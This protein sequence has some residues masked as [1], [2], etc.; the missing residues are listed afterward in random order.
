[1]STICE[2]MKLIQSYSSNE[3]MLASLECMKLL[4]SV[5]RKQIDL[6]NQSYTVDPSR[7]QDLDLMKQDL[8]YILEHKP[9]T[10]HQALQLFWLYALC[11]GCINY[12]RLDIV[13]GPFLKHDIDSGLIDEHEAYR[14]IKSLWKMIEN[15]RTTVNGRIIVG[16]K[17]RE[18]VEACDLFTRI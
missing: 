1:M 6:V 4:K 11:A 17:G 10:F 18:N 7:N 16:G 8:E 5:I 12:G 9:A 14:Y 13:L 3:F 2:L 15:R